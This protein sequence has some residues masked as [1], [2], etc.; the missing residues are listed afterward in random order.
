[1]A[2]RYSGRQEGPSGL[3]RPMTEDE[4]FA[5]LLGTWVAVPSSNVVEARYLD[6]SETLEIGFDGGDPARGTDYYALTG[7]SFGEAQLFAMS[8]SKGCW[9]HQNVVRA[10]R[11]VMTILKTSTPKGTRKKRQGHATAP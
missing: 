5:F 1:M 9:W 10:G 8:R 7:C 6:D 11:P 2:R 3:G 4:L